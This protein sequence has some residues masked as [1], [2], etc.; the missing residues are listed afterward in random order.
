M[1]GRLLR[2]EDK[3]TCLLVKCQGCFKLKTAFLCIIC[4]HRKQ[5]NKQPGTVSISNKL[6]SPTNPS[7][8]RAFIF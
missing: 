7:F 2:L 8:Q 5:I 1:I 3:K 6:N 4:V